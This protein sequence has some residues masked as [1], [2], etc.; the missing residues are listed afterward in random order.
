MRMHT[1]RYVDA[2]LLLGG[3]FR[4]IYKDLNFSSPYGECVSQSDFET[5]VSEARRIK[6]ESDLTF[7]IRHRI[8]NLSLNYVPAIEN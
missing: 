2:H 3:N 8:E 7:R 1:T 5:R 6:C 4:K